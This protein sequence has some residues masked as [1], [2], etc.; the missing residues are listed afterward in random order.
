MHRSRSSVAPRAHLRAQAMR[1]LPRRA[2]DSLCSAFVPEQHRTQSHRCSRKHDHGAELCHHFLFAMA[3]VRKIRRRC[4]IASR[5][6]RKASGAARLP[7][8]VLRRCAGIEEECNPRCEAEE[9]GRLLRSGVRGCGA[10][11]AHPSD[12]FS[13]MT[14]FS[15]DFVSPSMRR[16]AVSPSMCGRGFTNVFRVPWI[17]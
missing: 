12:V 4:W 10:A 3:M 7:R 16:T 8:G 13:D 1:S 2:A 15:S 9:I 14:V 5:T 11:E 17:Q 6:V